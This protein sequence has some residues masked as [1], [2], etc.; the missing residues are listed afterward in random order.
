MIATRYV[1]PSVDTLAMKI[2][3][4]ILA[5]ID[6]AAFEAVRLRGL[7]ECPKAF[8]SSYQ[9]E[10]LTSL[11]ELEARLESKPDA[12]IFGAFD[13]ETLVALVGIRRESKN[14]RGNCSQSICSY[15][16]DDIVPLIGVSGRMPS[17]PRSNGAVTVSFSVSEAGSDGVPCRSE[18]KIVP[19]Y[20]VAELKIQ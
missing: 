2:Q 12:A 16:H 8:A 3:I 15:S 18:L 9:E 6:A 5:P 4:R 1:H 7:Q 17:V 20:R 10:L 19:R 11:R 13:G 14:L